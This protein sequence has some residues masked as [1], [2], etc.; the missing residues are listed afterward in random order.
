MAPA[1]PGHRREPPRRV[2]N[3]RTAVLPKRS[4]PAT[5]WWATPNLSREEFDDAASRRAREA[6]SAYGA[7]PHRDD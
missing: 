4:A 1:R 3:E 5:S 7:I 2:F 6:G